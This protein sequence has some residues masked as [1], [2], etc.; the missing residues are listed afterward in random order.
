MVNKYGVNI[1]VRLE[2]PA[3][4]VSVSSTRVYKDAGAFAKELSNAAVLFGHDYLFSLKEG[5]KIGGC[6]S[7]EYNYKEFK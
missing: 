7:N 3:S 2:I 5:S 1:P 6:I 4:E